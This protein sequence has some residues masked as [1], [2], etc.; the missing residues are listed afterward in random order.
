LY[1]IHI[2]NNGDLEGIAGVNLP[3]TVVLAEMLRLNTSI[4]S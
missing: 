3:T 1:E 4:T 2:N